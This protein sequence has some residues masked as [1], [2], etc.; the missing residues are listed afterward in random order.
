MTTRITLVCP[1]K[2]ILRERAGRVLALAAEEF[3]GVELDFAEQCFVET[4]HFA[5][6]DQTRLDALVSA[7]NAIVPFGL[8]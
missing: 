4:G 2:P 6:D 1:G 8:A 7:A 3:P 5:G